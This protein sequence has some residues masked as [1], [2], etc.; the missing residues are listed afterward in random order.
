MKQLLGLSS[1]LCMI[2]VRLNRGRHRLALNHTKGPIFG[3]I[4]AARLAEHF[5][6]PIRHHEEDEIKLPP[7]ILDYKSMVAHKFIV[8]NEEKMLLYNLRFNK[9]HNDTIILPAP[10]LFDLIA[11]NFLVTP[12]AVYAHRGQASTP[13]P[14]PEP[15]PAPDPY[16]ASSY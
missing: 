7:H 11:D 14:E 3:G 10:L 15:E 5:Q 12:E 4:Y 16:R 8:D 9:K 13:E 1:G 2:S 6:I